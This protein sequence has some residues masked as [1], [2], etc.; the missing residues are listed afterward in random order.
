M[1]SFALLCT[2]YS[3]G[4]S[5]SLLQPRLAKP[6]SSVNAYRPGSVYTVGSC[7]VFHNLVGCFTRPGLVFRNRP[8]VLFKLVFGGKSASLASAAAILS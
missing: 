5:E 7:L 6:G 3:P 4:Y 1:V 8:T 2:C